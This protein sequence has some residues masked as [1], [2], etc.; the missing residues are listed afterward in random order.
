MVGITDG[1]SFFLQPSVI[2][3]HLTWERVRPGHGELTKSQMVS[4][5]VAVQLLNPQDQAA[6]AQTIET[7]VADTE[8]VDLQDRVQGNAGLQGTAKHARHPALFRL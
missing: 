6:M 1:R 4:N 8:L 7:Q 3:P 2:M 5:I